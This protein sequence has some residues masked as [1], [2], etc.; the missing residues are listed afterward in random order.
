MTPLFPGMNSYLENPEIWA[1]V[2]SWPIVQLAR[3]LNPVLKPKYRATVE[4]RVYTDSL[5][6]DFQW[7]QT[8]LVE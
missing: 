2:H 6:S 1:E 4:Q 8:L 5:L 3:S 7:I